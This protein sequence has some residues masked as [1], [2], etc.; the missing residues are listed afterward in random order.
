[1]GHSLHPPPPPPASLCLSLSLATPKFVWWDNTAHC[2]KKLC[3]TLLPNRSRLP[4]PRRTVHQ[5]ANLD[6]LMELATLRQGSLLPDECLSVWRHCR[7]PLDWLVI[8]AGSRANACDLHSDDPGSR[9][10][11]NTGCPDTICVAFLSPS[12]KFRDRITS[13]TI[14]APCTS[15]PSHCSLTSYKLS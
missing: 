1:M 11:R 14:T 9:L 3:A 13:S 8:L 4:I 12:R 15:F 6:W 2:H 5:S 7:I 10:G